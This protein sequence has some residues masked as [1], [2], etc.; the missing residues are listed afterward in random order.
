MMCYGVVPWCYL[1]RG[2]YPTERIHRGANNGE[3]MWVQIIIRHALVDCGP[4]HAKPPREA[5]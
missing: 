2:L 5:H 1:A 3:S 4:L